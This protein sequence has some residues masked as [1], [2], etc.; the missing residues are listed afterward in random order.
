MMP[1]ARN[2]RRR[3]RIV[4]LAGRAVH[5]RHPI[6]DDRRIA[7]SIGDAFRALSLGSGQGARARAGGNGL[8]RILVC[9]APRRLVIRR[10]SWRF[11]PHSRP[12]SLQRLLRV[13]GA[14]RRDSLSLIRR[15]PADAGT[16]RPP[17]L[18]GHASDARFGPSISRWRLGG[19]RVALHERCVHCGGFDSGPIT[20]PSARTTVTSLMPTN[21]RTRAGRLPG[22]RVRSRRPDPRT[23]RRDSRLETMTTRFSP[24]NPSGPGPVRGVAERAAGL[25]HAIDPGLQLR[26]HRDVVHRGAG[27]A[28]RRSPQRGTPGR[29]SR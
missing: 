27:Q 22:G 16:S 10:L 14:I 5:E 20:T 17:L 23:C 2:L 29:A 26:G 13:A 12:A 24:A 4:R 25:G 28:A 11:V 21:R 9:L 18:R 1:W 19:K 7:A 8:D 6:E 3:S 15:R